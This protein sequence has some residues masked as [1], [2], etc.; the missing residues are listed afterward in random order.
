GPQECD[1]E[2]CMEFLFLHLAT[3]SAGAG[4]PL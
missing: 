2:P 3:L 4:T 1:D